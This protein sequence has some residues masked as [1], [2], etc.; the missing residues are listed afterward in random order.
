LANQLLKQERERRG[1]SQARV[2]E[3]IESDPGTI[4]R[5][6]RGIS[7]PSPFFRERL[8]QLYGK[9]TE[10]LGL[11]DEAAGD[12]IAATTEI[13][14]G[15]GAEKS[16]AA[17]MP[18][19][20][21]RA[22]PAAKIPNPTRALACFCVAFGWL[23][24]L[25]TLLVSRSNAFV[26]FYALQSCFVFGAA[27]AALAAVIITLPATASVPVLRAVVPLGGILLAALTLFV[28]GISLVQAA[29]GEQYHFPFIGNYC[30]RLAAQL[31]TA[32]DSPINA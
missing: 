30:A 18:F 2:A 14:A 22:S 26:N 16:G 31:A 3:Q 15:N 29:R 7:S 25:L 27:S 9:T 24:S 20:T 28:W 8:C 5:W 10:E 19:A 32:N 23:G 12:P 1:W 17:H 6:E 4:S 21:S 13:A 11:L